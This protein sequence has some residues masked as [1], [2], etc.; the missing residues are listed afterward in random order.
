MALRLN[1]GCQEQ[2][3]VECNYNFD[4][5]S[6]RLQYTIANARRA[7][8]FTSTNPSTQFNIT[9]T[10]GS[11]TGFVTFSNL[12]QTI[13]VVAEGCGCPARCTLGNCCST[14]DFLR[15]SISGLPSTFNVVLERTQ[16]PP[17]FGDRTLYG[18]WELTITG[19]S[20][21]NGTWL[22]AVTN[23]TAINLGECQALPIDT[24]VDAT[25]TVKWTSNFVPTTEVWDQDL[26]GTITG[27][28]WLGKGNL[29][30]TGGA[31]TMVGT[32]N[33]TVGAAPAY[34]L[35]FNSAW[36]P[37][38]GLGPYVSTQRGLVQSYSA[39]TTNGFGSAGSRPFAVIPTIRCGQVLTST[40]NIMQIQIFDNW[41]QTGGGGGFGI[42]L[43]GFH[44]ET[45]NIGSIT[46]EYISVP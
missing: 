7:Y 13:T 2:P 12:T 35:T 22:T 16:P 32:A 42:T 37:N 23:P 26:T 14:K 21:L 24:G 25:F 11:A 27:R 39:N 4:Q 5:P 10:S 34:S 43:T 3:S 1:L 29:W 15:Q 20:G 18:R 19:L 9:L 28:I 31:G 6:V 30:P 17:Q 40:V 46:Q 36:S 33:K 8:Y 44:P 38:M 45:N 41:I